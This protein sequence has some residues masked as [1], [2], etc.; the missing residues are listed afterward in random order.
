MPLSEMAVALLNGKMSLSTPDSQS[1]TQR[2]PS[3]STPSIELH[4]TSH[5][6]M[7]LAAAGLCREDFRSRKIA[8]DVPEQ[9]FR[10]GENP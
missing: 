4:I 8:V 2:E 5:Q 7:I 3:A 6:I 1:Q 10:S 9:L